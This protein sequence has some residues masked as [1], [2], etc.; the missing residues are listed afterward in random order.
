MYV[1]SLGCVGVK[2]GESERCTIDMGVRQGCIMFPWIYI[3]IYGCS[4][5]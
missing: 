1:H 2:G 4:D 3:Y 5:E